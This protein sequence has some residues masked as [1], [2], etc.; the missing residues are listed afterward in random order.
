MTDNA[1]NR[2]LTLTRKKDEPVPPEEARED[3]TDAY[4]I[5]R[6]SK[7]EIRH[8]IEVEGLGSPTEIAARLNADGFPCAQAEAWNAKLVD[9]ALRRRD[10]LDLK[11]RLKENRGVEEPPKSITPEEIRKAAF[12]GAKD[13][14]DKMNLGGVVKE[15]VKLPEVKFPEIPPLKVDAFSI[16]ETVTSAV[17]QVLKEH[18]R[19]FEA[20]DRASAAEIVTG[21]REALKTAVATAFASALPVQDITAVRRTTDATSRNVGDILKRIDVVCEDLH[22]T[23]KTS[24][25][26]HRAEVASNCESMALQLCDQ[27]DKRMDSLET[28]LVAKFSS[29]GA[30][31]AILA[32]VVDARLKAH[33]DGA[34]NQFAVMVER[35][36]RDLREER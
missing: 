4:E 27:V 7:A 23:V 13:A 18:L 8:L 26:K 1:R 25:E 5:P 17:D 34:V 21:V 29:H 36:K 3:P 24:F 6:A 32:R 30:I 35:L 19:H 14:F 22:D 15:A 11:E 9:S 10:M 12:D 28:T 20:A 31:D 2:R 33:M 16:K